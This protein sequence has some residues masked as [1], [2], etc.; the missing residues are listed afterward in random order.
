MNVPEPRFRISRHR[1]TAWLGQERAAILQL[2]IQ[3]Q[4]PRQTYATK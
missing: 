4:L 1:R 2:L 3:Q